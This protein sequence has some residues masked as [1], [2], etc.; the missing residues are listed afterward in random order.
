MRIIAKVL[1]PTSI[2]ADRPGN[3]ARSAVVICHG[4]GQQLKWQ[5]LGQLVRSLE[6]SG[7]VT[8][9]EDIG[10]RQV[11]FKSRNDEFFLG[12]AEVTTRVSSA[13]ASREVH[14]YE[15]Y[16]APLTEG[17]VSLLQTLNFL[18]SA[19]LG[20]IRH[21]LTT[22]YRYGRFGPAQYT[23]DREPDPI[24]AFRLPRD[25]VAMFAGALLVF[26]SL[27]VMNLTI[28][29]RQFRELLSDTDML[30]RNGSLLA[31]L[32]GDLWTFELVAL[33]YAIL[34]AGCVFT[35]ERRRHSF[36]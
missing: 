15:A 34:L 3:S 2:E 27:V 17:R 22:F 18:L 10:V 30:P 20:G 23:D 31:A 7:E 5:T 4:M 32:T 25:L 11:R 14:I 26:L 1:E 24:R 28:S 13:K 19:C 36:R 33:A 35:R 16:W 9:A 12:R 29:V 6:R 8:S 21:S